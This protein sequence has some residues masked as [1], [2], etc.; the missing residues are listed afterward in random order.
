MDSI[1]MVNPRIRGPVMMTEAIH[2]I[3]GIACRKAK[4]IT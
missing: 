3:T 2:P 4:I 1:N